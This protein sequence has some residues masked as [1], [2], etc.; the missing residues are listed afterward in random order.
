VATVGRAAKP[1]LAKVVSL[2]FTSDHGKLKDNDADWKN[3]GT[4]IADPEFVFGKPSAPISQTR[5]TAL[6]VTIEIELYPQRLEARS[7]AVQGTATWGGITFAATH[8][9]KGG[10]QTVKLT[11]NEKL[12]DKIARLEGDIEWSIVH[13]ALGSIRADHS[14]GHVIFVTMDTPQDD[15]AATLQED[16]VTVKRMKAASEWVAPLATLRPHSIVAGIME[17]VPSYVLAPND[18]VPGR[19]RHPSYLNNSDGGAW[20]LHEYAAYFAECQA[21]C[22]LTRAILRQ[23]GVPGKVTIAVVW[24]EPNG[25]D[26]LTKEAD[27]EANPQAGLNSIRVVDGRRQVAAL[28]DGRVVVGKKYA[29]SHEPMPDGTISP[30]LNR[31]EAC[32]N[33]AAEGKTTYYGGGA[34]QYASKEEVIRAFWGLV[35]VEFQVDG[36]Y[37]VKAIVKRYR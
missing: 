28:A 34:G 2:A 36:G 27:W 6:T 7:Y 21:I 33:F 11:S 25:T 3:T 18:A 22:R 31:Y 29:A 4:L 23:L 9:L 20:P 24:A 30:G 37:I 1:D 19:L 16:G 10:K 26:A 13:S 32:L 15:R 5:N 17:K 14:F 8:S 35:W 12:P